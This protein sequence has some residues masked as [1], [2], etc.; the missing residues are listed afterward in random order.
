LLSDSEPPHCSCS[1]LVDCQWS[2]GSCPA[3][4][5]V[6]LTWR[7]TRSGKDSPRGTGPIGTRSSARSRWCSLLAPSVQRIKGDGYTLQTD[8]KSSISILGI[9]SSRED[10]SIVYLWFLYIDV[11]L[12]TSSGDQE[13]SVSHPECTLLMLA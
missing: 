2:H 1:N 4:G 7:E 13:V 11:D 3:N 9:Y 5:G 12:G 10:G 8:S 6:D